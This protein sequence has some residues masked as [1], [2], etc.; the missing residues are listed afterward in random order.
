MS[1]GAILRGKKLKGRSI[2]RTAAAHNLRAIQAEIG[3]S[4]S[5]DPSRS[6][7]NEI[8]AG[9][10]LPEQVQA[11]ADASLAEAGLGDSLRRDAV[12]CL[13]FVVSLPPGHGCDEKGFFASAVNWLADRFG[14]P[15]NLLSA[16][17]HR[18]EAAPHVHALILPLI[19]GRMVGS[20]AMGGPKQ[21]Q[22]MQA[23][24]FE[25][26]GKPYGL[27]AF[28][29][30]IGG[31]QKASLAAKVIRELRLR[32]DAALSSTI[33]PVIRERIES[34]PAPF[35]QLI[36][37]SLDVEA[38]P[39]KLRSM[40]AIFISKGKGSCKPESEAH[41]RSPTGRPATQ[42]YPV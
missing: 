2:V 16:V 17:I 20:D 37:V 29:R 30:Q 27:K 34:D 9:E 1:A 6:H 22:A 7:M 10:P 33:W 41:C 4:A 35:A 40:T 15:G 14:G 19:G 21:L 38:P 8:L 42:P 31:A 5:I 28:P 25:E 23:D 3:A 39:K 36:G 32:Q 11:R 26:V 24:F 13:E 18:D 12:R